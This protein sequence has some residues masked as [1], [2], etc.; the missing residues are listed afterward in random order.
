MLMLPNP[1]IAEPG[2]TP[3]SPTMVVGPVLVTPEPPR[4]A[5]LPAVPKSGVV[6]KHE[7]AMPVM[8]KVPLPLL[9]VNVPFPLKVAVTAMVFGGVPA[10]TVKTVVATPLTTATLVT[11]P[12]VP[13][14]ESDRAAVWDS[15]YTRDVGRQGDR[16]IHGCA[17]RKSRRK[18]KR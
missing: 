9:P 4:T 12:Q 17:E 13:H 7:L 18:V 8:P 1:V 2:L 11:V 16:L 15:A 6:P 10:G 5:K 3:R 14:R